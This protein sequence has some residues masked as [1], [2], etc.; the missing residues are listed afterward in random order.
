MTIN[1]TQINRLLNTGIKAI[2][3]NY[4]LP[5]DE[6]K[7]I[8]KTFGS[9]KAS[10]QDLEMRFLGPADIK[11][12]GAEFAV[13]SM[14]QR[15]VTNYKHKTVGLSFSMTRE[16]M[17]DNLYKDQFPQ[18]ALALKNS[19]RATKNILA[20]NVLNNAFN[21]VNPIGDGMPLCSTAHPIDGGTF[22]NAFGAGG[23]TVDFSEAGLEQAI[24]NIQKFPQ[25]N[26]MLSNNM[27]MKVVV[28]RELQ[29]AARRLLLSAFRPEVA[30]NDIN[31]LNQGNYLPG[32]FVVFPYL[33]SS[34]AWFVLT[35]AE[36]G[37]KHYQR[38]EIH[39]DTTVDFKTNNIL[40]KAW[41]RYCF[42]AS[43]S[44]A[45]FGSPGV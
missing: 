21:P 4:D 34:T 18:Q 30:N 6:Y 24:I 3:G 15:I 12:E 13:D 45:I 7:Q 40:V 41:E 8:F 39:T 19:L 14:G 25:Q 1:T 9:T 16:A 36:H 38:E 10:E 20:A 27:P 26:G 29:F 31:A 23:A 2:F 5:N 42:G 43:N 35:D 28:P 32:G 22:S 11:A 17:Q 44:R 33:T 37:L